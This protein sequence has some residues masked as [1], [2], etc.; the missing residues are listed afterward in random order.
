LNKPTDS[1]ERRFPAHV[2]THVFSV[3]G[4]CFIGLCGHNLW[5]RLEN[6]KPR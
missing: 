4:S 5:R 1:Q 3:F 6:D 2:R